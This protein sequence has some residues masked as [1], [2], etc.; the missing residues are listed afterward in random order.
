MSDE[1]GTDLVQAEEVVDAEVVDECY[2]EFDRPGDCP[3]GCRTESGHPYQVQPRD[4]EFG[5]GL[6]VCLVKFSEHIWS[7]QE[8]GYR[9]ALLWS[10]MNENQ[11]AAALEDAARKP[12]GDNARRFGH[13][14]RMIEIYGTIEKYISSSLESWANAASDHFYDIDRGRAPKPLIELADLM[15][16][17]GHGFTGQIWTEKDYNKAMDLWRESAMELD[18]RLGTKPNWGNY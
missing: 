3:N 10:R 17:M 16:T 18:R 9:N 1:K 14:E 15:L 2:G 8:D 6:V 12:A 4:S 5:A 7:W 11:R 13:I